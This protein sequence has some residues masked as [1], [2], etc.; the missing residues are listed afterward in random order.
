MT[1][2]DDLTKPRHTIMMFNAYHD[3]MMEHTVPLRMDNNSHY[4]LYDG[5]FGRWVAIGMSDGV[6]ARME[7]CHA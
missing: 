6:R 4:I 7:A 1:T 5:F 2:I 3:K